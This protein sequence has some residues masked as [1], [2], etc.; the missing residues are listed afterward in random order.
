[1]REFHL[2]FSM[3]WLMFRALI[4]DWVLGLTAYFIFLNVLHFVGRYL[5]AKKRRVV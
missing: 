1:M 2:A 5:F 3:G 4:D